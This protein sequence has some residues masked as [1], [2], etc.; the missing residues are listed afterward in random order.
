MAVIECL[1]LDSTERIRYSRADATKFIVDESSYELDAVFPLDKN[2]PIVNGMLIGFY[3]IDNDLVFY[4]IINNQADPF[5]KT[6][7]VYAELAVLPELRDETI[8]DKRPTKTQAGAAAMVA[9]EGTRWQVRT[10][11]DVG[12]GSCRFWYC[13]VWAALQKIVSTWGCALKFCWEVDDTG[14]IARYVDVKASLGK[15]RGKRFELSKGISSLK[16]LYDDSSVVT[17]L[18]GRGKGEE[19]ETESGD[20]A[21]GRKISFADVEWSKANGDPADKPLGQEWIEDPAATA[22]LGRRG[23]KRSRVIN[24]DQCE[25]KLELISLT[26]DALQQL[27]TPKL[28]IRGTV[29]DLEMSWG[30]GFEAVRMGDATAFLVDEVDLEVL[31]QAVKIKRNYI[32]PDMT[33]ITLGN[34]VVTISDLQ[35]QASISINKTN[36]NALIGAQVASKNPQLLQGIIDTMVTR[37]LSSG[38]N[39]YT[40][41]NDGSLVFE[42]STNTEAVKITGQGILLADKKVDGQWDWG[43]A[44][45]G[46]GMVADMIT[47]GTL[48]ANLIRILGSDMFYWDA[49]NIHIFDPANSNNEIR[50]GLYDGTHYGVGFTRDGGATWTTAIDFSG[51]HVTAE[52]RYSGVT[53]TNNSLVFIADAKGLCQAKT[54]TS[55]I[56]AYTGQ[57]KVTPTVASVTGAPDGMVITIGAAASYEIPITIRVPQGATLGGTDQQSGTLVVNISKPIVTKLEINWCKVNA[58]LD[59]TNGID[60]QDGKDGAAGKDGADAINTVSITLY[61]RSASTPTT[62][63]GACSY[64]FATGALTGSLQGWSRSIPSGTDPCYGIAAVVIS[65]LSDVDVPSGAWSAPLALFANG[66][67]GKDGAAGKDGTNGKDGADGKDGAQGAS[68][69]NQ[70][71]INLYMRSGTAPAAPSGETIYTFATGGLTGSI[72]SWSRNIPDGT[73]PCYMISATAVSANATV[74]IPA[75]SWTTPVKFVQNGANGQDGQNGKDGAAGADGADGVDG[76]NSA[77]IYL[78]KRAEEQPAT[79]TASLQYVFATASL[80]GELDGWTQSIPTTNGCPCWVSLAQAVANTSVTTLPASA[81]TS[82]AKL[83][84]DGEAGAKTYYCPDAPTDAK[85]QDLWVDSDDDN[86]LYRYNGTEWVSI[87]DLN[88]PAVIEQLVSAET[89]LNVLSSSIESKVSET[90][91]TN[92]L[93]QLVKSLN[94]TISQTAKDLRMEFQSTAQDAAGNV[95]TKYSTLIRASGDGVEVGKSDSAFRTLLANDRLSFLQYEDGVS[96]EV[97]YVSNKKLYITEARITRELSIGPADGDH[98]SWKKTSTGLALDY[99]SA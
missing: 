35:A 52:D 48:Q 49:A 34:E 63:P 78:Y 46:S 96:T 13:S 89:A 26:W 93:D 45:T 25:D 55:N 60:G 85:E 75:S 83:V 30:Y 82:P 42:N 77:V 84:E 98:F 22:A 5:D 56:I 51:A 11:E 79:P 97:A 92:Q 1:F 2:K 18:Y 99:I 4:E 7:S 29:S 59:G 94:S 8:V 38:T 15:W 10:V 44:I 81:W 67:D 31:I 74:T 3:D 23:R 39:M 41:P 27:K 20:T 36:Q 50:I 61:K 88:I 32:N 91:V 68:G 6:V 47:S 72:G 57:N 16:I 17:A 33:N 86:K 19:I 43:T 64:N 73:A 69:I 80:A 24:F 87:Q 40:D 65:S 28:T 58:G 14:I 76:L 95:D 62:F 9:L 37:V 66:A 21:Y 54:Y 53:C 70:A 12:I 71:V 90:Y